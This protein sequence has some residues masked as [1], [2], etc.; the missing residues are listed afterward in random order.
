MRAVLREARSRRRTSTGRREPKNGRPAQARR[1]SQGGRA[2]CTAPAPGSAA[3]AS[4]GVQFRALRGGEIGQVMSGVRPS[5]PCGFTSSPVNGLFLPW[6]NG[7]RQ[8]SEHVRC[9]SAVWPTKG[10][11]ARAREIQPKRSCHAYRPHRAAV[12]G[13][14]PFRRRV[15]S[16]G[17]RPGRTRDARPDGHAV[18]IRRQPALGRRP[19]HRVAAH[20]RPDGRAHRD[21]DGHRRPGALGQLQ[22]LLDPGSCRRRRRRRP[23]RV[24]R[25]P[26]RRA[27]V[28]LE[29]RVAR[30]VLVV[31]RAGAA[32]ARRGRAEH[33]P[34]RR[35]RRHAPGPQ[36][37]RIREGRGGTRS[38]HGG[39]RGV[40]VRPGPPRA[41]PGRRPA[42]LD[43]HRQRGQRRHRGDDHRRPPPGRHGEE[44]RAALPRHQRERLG[45]QVEVRQQ[46]RLPALTDRRHQPGHRRAH[47]RQGGRSVRLRRRRQ[48]LC[49]VAQRPGS[50][51]G[52]HRGR[53][54]LRPPGRH[55]GLPGHHPGGHPAHRRHHHH[56]DGEQ[57]HHHGPAHGRA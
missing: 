34:R 44:G 28:R 4:G 17:D 7:L 42:A 9:A 31:H 38:L 29:G 56:H 13:G 1:L 15:R 55:G 33:D 43:L 6:V 50:P 23:P 27:G 16:Q 11:R 51:G 57:G 14:R 25:E 53:S 49:P 18:R 20:D 40:P 52:G 26:A 47:R 12:Q 46:V 39:V 36:G 32:L 3:E 37:G 54:H 35:R 30:G 19:H 21:T 8:R 45:D 22:H 2:E 5:P 41:Q 24:G 10:L 48:G